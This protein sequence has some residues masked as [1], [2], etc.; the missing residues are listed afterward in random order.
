MRD[1]PRDLLLVADVADDGER[2]AAGR[3]DLRGRV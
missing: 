3:L 2:P 1:G